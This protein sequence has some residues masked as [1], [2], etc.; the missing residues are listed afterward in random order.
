MQSPPTQTDSTPSPTGTTDSSQHP[1]LAAPTATD[2]NLIKDSN[3][4]ADLCVTRLRSG[5]M[6]MKNYTD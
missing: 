4:E 3:T 2:S 5:T 1:I 6:H